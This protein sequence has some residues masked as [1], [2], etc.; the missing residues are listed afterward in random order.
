M[1]DRFTIPRPPSSLPTG[2]QNPDTSDLFIPSCG[3]EDV[4]VAF[5]NLFDKELRLFVAGDDASR[6]AAQKKVPVIFASGE[7]WALLKKGYPLRDKAGS[8]ILPLITIARTS[9]DQGPEDVNGRGINQQTGELVIKRKLAAEDRNYQNL[10]NRLLLPNSGDVSINPGMPSTTA[11]P[12][13]TLRQIGDRK[14]DD[15]VKNSALLSPNRLNNTYEI[16]T[17]PSPQ[18]FTCKY[19][20]TIWTQYTQQM[21]NMLEVVMS[22]LLPQ[23]RCFKLTTT[24]G[25]WFVA[26]MEDSYAQEVNFDDMSGKERVIKYKLSFKVPAYLLASSAPGVPIPVRRFVSSPTVDF[27]V[28]AVDALDK[29]IDYPYPGADDPTLPLFEGPPNDP[30]YRSKSRNFA[31]YDPASDSN[32]RGPVGSYKRLE[33]GQLVKIASQPNGETVYRLVR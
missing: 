12:R 23:G 11:D 8:L 24:K 17:L 13:Y 28:A 26:Y 1:T 10:I 15:D 30:S 21:N 25:Y 14:E 4:D 16:I 32:P 29:Q 6:Q 19:D 3:L 5:F 9:L 7:K 22:S 27:E 2:Y 18:F 33:K 31:S 20:V